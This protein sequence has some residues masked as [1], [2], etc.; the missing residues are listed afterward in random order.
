ME[1]WSIE[2][3][4]RHVSAARWKDAHRALLVEAAL[5]NGAVDGPGTS[6]P[7]E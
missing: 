6:S 4:N 2:V 5:T 3:L 7:G 1:W